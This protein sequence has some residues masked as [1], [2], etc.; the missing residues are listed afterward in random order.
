MEDSGENL[1][2][3]VLSEASEREKEKETFTEGER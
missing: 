2:E 1:G 3:L